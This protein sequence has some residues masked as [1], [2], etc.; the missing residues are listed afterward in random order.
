MLISCRTRK[1]DVNELVEV[2]VRATCVDR[3]TGGGRIS[4]DIAG[5]ELASSELSNRN[6]KLLLDDSLGSGATERSPSDLTHEVCPQ[7]E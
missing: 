5:L 7:Q 3:A 1:E 6:S 4:V 2:Q